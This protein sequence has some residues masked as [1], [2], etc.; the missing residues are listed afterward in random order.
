[1]GTGTKQ[2]LHFR[3]MCQRGQNPRRRLLRS[4]GV[5]CGCDVGL[6][7]DRAVGRGAV[8]RGG[9]EALWIVGVAGMKA[10]AGEHSSDR[11]CSPCRLTQ[12]A[13]RAAQRSCGNVSWK[14][15]SGQVL[16][17]PAVPVLNSFATPGLQGW[18]GPLGREW[19]QCCAWGA[20]A[21]G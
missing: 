5:E 7:T 15:G 2:S 21:E 3:D 11:G 17:V 20:G 6:D 14:R 13:R 10:L 4:G 8:G 19:G 9:R 12:K 18:V 1:M 16:R